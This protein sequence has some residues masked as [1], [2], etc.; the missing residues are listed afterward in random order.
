MFA[1]RGWLSRRHRRNSYR[2][3]QSSKLFDRGY[4]RA[5]NLH[6]LQKLQ[7]PLWHFLHHGSTGKFSPSVSFDASY[8]LEKNDDVRQATINPLYHYEVHGQAE[9]RLPLRSALEA[10]HH[11]IPEASL[12]RSFITPSLGQRRV[13]LLIDAST[14]P[15]AMSLPAGVLQLCAA[16]A[17][18]QGATLRILC[19]PGALDTREMFP[20][21]EGFSEQIQMSLEITE[22]PT[23]LSYSD[24]P[25]FE[26]EISI[27]TSWSSAL[28]LRNATAA[29]LAWICHGTQSPG[30]T[31]EKLDLIR[32]CAGAR[33]RLFQEAM[34]VPRDL[35]EQSELALI[36]PPKIP[37]QRQIAVV[38]NADKYPL[39]YARVIEALSIFI[40]QYD[41]DS[42]PPSICLVGN[43]GPRMAFVEEVEPLHVS[44]TAG[45]Q[46]SV[47]ADCVL[48]LS[49]YDDSLPS[50]LRAQGLTVV[51]SRP[52]AVG[53]AS[54][55]GQPPSSGADC[56][57]TVDE[58]VSSLHEALT[59]LGEKQRGF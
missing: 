13:S 50:L 8:Y 38:V 37:E 26:D 10:A 56:G 46:S 19:R 47:A 17:E 31:A 44:I 20:V 11:V 6:G 35:L 52:R 3:L 55:P 59:A 34:V 15:G 21:I 5:Q 30:P 32:N 43:T 54:I 2:T 57:L 48:V 29:G 24:I 4:Y 45:S 7:D 39:A 40:I 36:A 9:R 49:A 27:A 51:H 18:E 53:Q 23:T 14:A 41:A 33:E 12:L 16:Y 1:P 25:F 58:I 42:P 28:A 22:V